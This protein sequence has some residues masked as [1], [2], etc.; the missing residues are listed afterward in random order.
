[1]A[2]VHAEVSKDADIVHI[3]DEIDELEQKNRGNWTYI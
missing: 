1:M 2:S 3:H